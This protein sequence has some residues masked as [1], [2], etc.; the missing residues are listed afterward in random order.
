MS[1][2]V[3]QGVPGA[4]LDFDL[5]IGIAPREYT[6]GPQLCRNLGF[7]LLANTVV[8]LPDDTTV[9]FIYTVHGLAS[10]KTETGRAACA[11][12]WGRKVKVLS[13]AQILKSKQFIN[14]PK[15]QPHIALIQRALGLKS[16]RRT[17]LA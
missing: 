15:D 7:K 14:R 17:P 4:T 13:L 16:K 6:K 3:L 1:A 2:A 9:N 8:A 5:W 10:F 12:I 11:Q